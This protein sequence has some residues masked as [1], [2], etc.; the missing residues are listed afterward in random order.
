MLYQLNKWF[1]CILCGSNRT[2]KKTVILNQFRFLNF[3]AFRIARASKA[4]RCLLPAVLPEA[5][6]SAFP[7]RGLVGG[8]GVMVFIQKH[9]LKIIHAQFF[10][11][12]I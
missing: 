8:R 5:R 2:I 3:L 7:F 11:G 1:Y 10:N 12:K 6:T 4:G 9:M